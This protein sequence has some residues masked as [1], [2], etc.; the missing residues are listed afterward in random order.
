[1]AA[2]EPSIKAEPREEGMS[3]LLAAAEEHQSASSS[4]AASPVPAP[5]LA[6]PSEHIGAAPK[7]PTIKDGNAS[8]FIIGMRGS[9]KVCPR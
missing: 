7:K 6:G 1:M 3:A 5:A 8:L 9:G 4:T 2:S